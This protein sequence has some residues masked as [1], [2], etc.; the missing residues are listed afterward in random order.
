[1]RNTSG[2]TLVIKHLRSRAS[3]CLFCYF[4]HHH[5]QGFWKTI[6]LFLLTS[7]MLHPRILNP[8]KV[9]AK[10]LIPLVL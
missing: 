2:K 6:E 8:D 9:T 3:R 7:W 10:S 1:M 5:P 4:Q